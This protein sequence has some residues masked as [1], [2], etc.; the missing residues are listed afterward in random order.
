[1]LLR[2]LLAFLLAA[3]IPGAGRSAPCDPS[4]G[5]SVRT[6]SSAQYV[7]VDHGGATRTREG[8]VLVF[9]HGENR[10]L[11]GVLERDGVP[12]LLDS[13]P[14]RNET[15]VTLPEDLGEE[16]GLYVFEETSPGR[17][18]PMLR[19][20]REGEG[21]A[22]ADLPEGALDGVALAVPGRPEELP[23]KAPQP[24]RQP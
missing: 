1:M 7:G 16:D 23:D 5:L 6:M 18:T 14:L 17:A 8:R 22:L 13:R 2:L 3:S 21:F 12:Q 19:L 4:R 9:C 10:R 11:F 24:R 20:A 15:V